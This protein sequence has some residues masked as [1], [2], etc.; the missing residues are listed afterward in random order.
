MILR[1]W[2]G[3]TPASKADAYLE[4]MRTAALPAYKQVEGCLGAWVTRRF[5]GEVAHFETLSLWADIAAIE[6]FA[7]KPVETAK[8]DDFDRDY[9]LEFEPVVNHVEC[10][11][12]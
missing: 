1:T 5:E 4:L 11:D 7:G 12:A 2:H 8:Y 6:G 9:L 10:W 3:R